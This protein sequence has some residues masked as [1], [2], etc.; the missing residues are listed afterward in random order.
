[1]SAQSPISQPRVKWI[2]KLKPTKELVSI[3]IAAYGLFY[4]FSATRCALDLDA[5]VSERTSIETMLSSDKVELALRGFGPAQTRK[6][7]SLP[8]NILKPWGWFFHTEVQPYR[9]RLHDELE[10][11][12]RQHSSD[13]MTATRRLD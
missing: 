2:Q 12:L 13:Y 1:M 4:E 6:V 7:P 8:P 5:A 10:S 9:R 11:A 3:I